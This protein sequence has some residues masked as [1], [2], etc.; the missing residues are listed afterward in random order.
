MGRGRESGRT[1]TRIAEFCSR[2]AL[3]GGPFR[4]N[5]DKTLAKILESHRGRVAA[6]RHGTVHSTPPFPHEA[7]PMSKSHVI[8]CSQADCRAPAAYKIAAPGA[9]VISRS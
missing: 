7:W 4:L 5:R 8:P 1:I 2:N 6:L 9:T 3:A